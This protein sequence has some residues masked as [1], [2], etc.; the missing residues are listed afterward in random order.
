M[1]KE[2]KSVPLQVVT[3]FKPIT[4]QYEIQEIATVNN[5]GKINTMSINDKRID[6]YYEYYT[7]PKLDEAAYLTAK[8]RLFA[9]V[10][11]ADGT[12]VVWADD[13]Q[14]ERVVDLAHARE[15][16]AKEHDGLQV[17]NSDFS[18]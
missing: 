12:A 11:D 9:E 1:K 5:D 17:Y 10:L 14:S 3:T 7:A 15:I 18:F 2:T 13:P 8:L 6:A 16:L 4:T